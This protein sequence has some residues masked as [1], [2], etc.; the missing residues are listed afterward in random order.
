LAAEQVDEGGVGGALDGRR[1]QLHVQDSIPHARDGRAAGSGGDANRKQHV[2]RNCQLSATSCQP[3]Y[4]SA[5]FSSSTTR[6]M[7]AAGV[8]T[9]RGRWS[10][11]LSSRS[12]TSCSWTNSSALRSA[13]IVPS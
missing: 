4:A 1:R 5:T 9:V 3:Y 11:T 12:L 6:S 10:S 7:G 2:I 13:A 8:S